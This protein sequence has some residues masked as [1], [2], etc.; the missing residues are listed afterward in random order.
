VVGGAEIMLS[1]FIRDPQFQ[2]QTK[3]RPDQPG[4]RAPG[5]DRD[6]RSFR[7]FPGRS[8]GARPRPARL[9]PR[10][11]GRAAEAQGRARGEA[12]ARDLV[13]QAAP[14]RQAHRLRQR[15]SGRHR[16][17]HRRGDS[18]GGS[19]K[20]ARDRKTQAILPIRGKILNVASASADKI[21]ANSEIADLIQALG[22][23]TRDRCHIE[24]LRYERIVIMTDADVDGAHIATC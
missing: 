22:C 15:R 10:S 13:A 12:Q 5:R 18:A 19:A 1:V 24:Q 4:R 3:D 21:R 9:H 20:Q 2:S 23:G 8:H 16:I 6:P 11:H 17:V 7:S 14:A